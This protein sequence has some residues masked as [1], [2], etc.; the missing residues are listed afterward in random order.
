MTHPACPKCNHPTK[1]IEDGCAYDPPSLGGPRVTTLEV[2]TNDECEWSRVVDGP[3][4]S[5]SP[6]RRVEIGEDDMYAAFGG[7]A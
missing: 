6:R 1:D 5:G 3:R 2:C 7:A 4:A